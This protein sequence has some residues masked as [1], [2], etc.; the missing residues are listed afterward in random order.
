MRSDGFSFCFNFLHDQSL[1]EARTW[2][3]AAE[4]AGID[5]VGVP[6]SPVIARELGVSAAYCAASTQ[7]IGIMSAITNPV[8]RDPSVMASMLFSLDEIAP[9]R[10]MCGIGTGDSALWSVGLE[11]AR[12]ARLQEYIVAVKTLLAGEEATFEG[13]T[14]KPVWRSWSPPARVPVYVA[15]S[16]PKVLKMA[17]RVADGMVVFV[18]FAPENIEFARSTIAEGCAEV[19]RDPSELHVWWQTTVN[20]ADTVEEAMENSLGVNTSWMTMR[21][22]QGKQI[23]EEVHDKLVRFNADMENVAA[24]YRDMDRGRV[25]VSRAKEMGIYDWI[26]S[27]APGFWGPPEVIAKRLLEFK[28]I[29]MTRWQFYVAPFHGDR[30]DFVERFAGGVIPSLQPAL[31]RGRAGG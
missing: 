1:H 30:I 3:E 14:M 31:A 9:G 16:G 13:R 29:G 11:P 20:F 6:D 5:S 25:L 4:R 22:L 21:G 7:R 10:I 8:S 28:E 24:T 2:W 12:I 23:P 18:G 19:G 26:I 27:R 17:A 15:C